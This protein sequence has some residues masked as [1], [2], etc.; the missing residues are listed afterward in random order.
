VGEMGEVKDRD[1]PLSSPPTEGQRHVT[2]A[3]GQAC[4][5]YLGPIVEKPDHSRAG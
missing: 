2:P 1:L 4:S 3:R 5:S